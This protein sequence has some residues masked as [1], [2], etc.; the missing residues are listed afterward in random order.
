[1]DYF[2]IQVNH[3]NY[4]NIFF[5]KNKKM[6]IT[7]NIDN[8]AIHPVKIDLFSYNLENEK[9][10]DLIA[11]ITGY[12]F[13]MEFMENEGISLFPIFDGDSQ[14]F[15]E[16]YEALFENDDYRDEL[17]VINENLFYLSDIYVY[18]EYRQEGYFTMLVNQLE[19]I[20]KYVVKL[21]VGVIATRIYDFETIDQI[22]NIELLSEQEKENLKKKLTNVFID[23][24][25]NIL[26]H[27]NHY[28][29]KVL[30]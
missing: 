30:Y 19:E 20:L 2:K 24:D 22:D 1:M 7:S 27:D 18:E 16:L 12:Y 6:D 29:V 15:Y 21:N 11:S 3:D 14:E 10:G 26:E 4:R 5:M 8:L 28:L 17:E 13:D 25:Y 9:N 23:N